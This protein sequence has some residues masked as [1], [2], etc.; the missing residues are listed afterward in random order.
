MM[1]GGST[2]GVVERARMI[3]PLAKITSEIHKQHRARSR[4]MVKIMGRREDWFR[5][6]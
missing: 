5:I 2:V 3:E 4:M 6:E 1:V